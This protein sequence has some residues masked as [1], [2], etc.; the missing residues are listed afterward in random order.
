MKLMQQAQHDVLFQADIQ[1][2]TDDFKNSKK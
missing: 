2:V 1:A